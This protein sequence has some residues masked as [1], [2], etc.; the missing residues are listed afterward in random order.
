MKRL[1]CTCERPLTAGTA[2]TIDIDGGACSRRALY[3]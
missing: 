2:N 1:V 3:P